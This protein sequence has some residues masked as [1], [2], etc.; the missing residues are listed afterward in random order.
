MFCYFA[1]GFISSK[2]YLSM[3]NMNIGAIA[4]MQVVGGCDARRQAVV[5]DTI[6]AKGDNVP[7]YNEYQV[8]LF[9]I[10]LGWS[11]CSHFS[12]NIFS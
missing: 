3:I 11:N 9:M 5:H 2:C 12:F 6:S 7:F 1:M 4:C 10:F 8:N